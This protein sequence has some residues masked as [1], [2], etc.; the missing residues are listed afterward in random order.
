MHEDRE[1]KIIQKHD[2]VFCQ[3]EMNIA[4]SIMSEFLLS[5]GD[6]IS[7]INK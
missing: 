6:N 7:L 5:L 4:A 3:S 2:I 1:D